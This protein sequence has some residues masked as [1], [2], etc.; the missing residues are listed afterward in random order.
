MTQ[1]SEE[2]ARSRSLALAVA[3]AVGSAF[4]L[5]IAV[6]MLIRDVRRADWS[7]VI[8]WVIMLASFTFNAYVGIRRIRNSEL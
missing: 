7:W 3:R 4:F 6:C 8:F 5:G 2:V 1:D